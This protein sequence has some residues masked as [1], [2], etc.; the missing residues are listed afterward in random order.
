MAIDLDVLVEIFGDDTTTDWRYLLSLKYLRL[1]L[2]FSV[3]GVCPLLL[4]SL[5]CVPINQKSKP[6]DGF[7]SLYLANASKNKKHR[8]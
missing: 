7:K 5:K 6:M 3:V 8:M 1:L 4:H 2:L